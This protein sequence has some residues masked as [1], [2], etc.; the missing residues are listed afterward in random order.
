[1]LVI[2]NV[3]ILHK[4]VVPQS[5][6]FLG[7]RAAVLDGDVEKALKYTNAF[8]PNVLKDNEHVYFRLRC[9]KFIEMIR[10]GAEL[11]NST[12][13]NGTKKSNGHNGDWYDDIINQEMD[14]DDHPNQNNWDRMDTEEPLGN[15]ME[16][17]R[18]LSETL[19][20]GQ[21]LQAEFQNDPR[22]EV[23][24]ALKDAFALIAYEDPINAK[25]VSHLLDPSGRVAVAEELN[26]AILC[27]F[28]CLQRLLAAYLIQYSV[29]WQIFFSCFR[30]IISTDQRPTRGPPRRWWSGCFRKY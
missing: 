23:S 13:T 10:Q 3:S 16:Y 18:L 5:N 26:S 20:Y 24:M 4:T 28:A 6:S 8:Y 19:A 9:R 12:S 17:Q 1:M 29:S 15:Q 25:E 22:R 27:K 7:I 2:D 11:H 14:V 30:A 21:D